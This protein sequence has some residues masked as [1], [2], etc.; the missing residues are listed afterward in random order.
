MA[1]SAKEYL[2]HTVMCS[3]L[4]AL[5]LRAGERI[6]ARLGEKV[7]GVRADFRIRWEWGGTLHL[8]F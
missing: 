6:R 2:Y 1:L 5:E 4:P 8:F 3:L 7:V